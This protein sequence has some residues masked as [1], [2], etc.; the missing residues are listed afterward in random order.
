M[1]KRE[2]KV[3]LKSFIIWLSILIFIFLLVYLI[4]PFILTD[5]AMKNIDDPKEYWTKARKEE[6]KQEITYNIEK[7]YLNN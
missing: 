2:L 1:I 5:E 7:Y 6:F 3:N 4:Y